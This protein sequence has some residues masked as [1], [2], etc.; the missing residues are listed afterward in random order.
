MNNDIMALIA[1]YNAMNDRMKKW[2]ICKKIEKYEAS[3]LSI[4][5]RLEKELENFPDENVP[6]NEQLDRI[7]LMYSVTGN[8]KMFFSHFYYFSGEKQYE[9]GEFLTRLSFD[10]LQKENTTRHGLLKSISY[11]QFQFQELKKFLAS[12][13]K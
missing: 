13:A 3:I 7:N 8:K 2:Y 9:F 11:L 1:Q 5:S 4:I 6:A 12:Y 10:D